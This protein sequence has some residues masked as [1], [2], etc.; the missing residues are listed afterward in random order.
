MDG[1][2]DHSLVQGGH[3]L[4]ERRM[5]AAFLRRE[6][7]DLAVHP[8]RPRYLACSRESIHPISFS[9]SFLPNAEQRVVDTFQAANSHYPGRFNIM[10]MFRTMWVITGDMVKRI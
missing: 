2:P 9:Y 4:R 7:S 10:S 1:L 8:W 6:V 5:V 3:C